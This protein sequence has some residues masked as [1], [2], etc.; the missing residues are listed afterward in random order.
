MTEYMLAERG[1]Y[2]VRRESPIGIVIHTALGFLSKSPAADSDGAERVMRYGQSEDCK[3]SWHAAVDPK[4]ILYGVAPDNVAW[5]AK[6]YNR[7]TLGVELACAPDFFKPPGRP[8]S[9]EYMGWT[10]VRDALLDNAAN[11]CAYWCH[12]FDILPH[13]TNEVVQRSGTAGKVV[14]GGIFG[15]DYTSRYRRLKGW[16][17]KVD[18]GPSFPW[19]IFA[20]KV[21]EFKAQYDAGSLVGA[22]T[23]GGDKTVEP[24]PIR[25][26]TKAELAKLKRFAATLKE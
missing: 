17:T 14:E 9:A 23:G 12:T 15:H 24:R 3:V 21:R 7:R 11:L 26:F 1:N 19:P 10:E 16:G 8:G 20:R 18:P 25:Q 6:G 2:G 22:P 4:H 13:I 5:H